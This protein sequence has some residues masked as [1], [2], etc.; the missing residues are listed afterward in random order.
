MV[1]FF[2]LALFLGGIGYIVFQ[3]YHFYLSLQATSTQMNRDKE[4][5]RDYLSEMED[6]VI[7]L[8]QDEIK[9]LSIRN[10]TQQ[11]REFKGTF[12]R[13]L[14][15]TVYTEPLFKFVLKEYSSSDRALLII[16]TLEGEILYELAENNSKVYW[17]QKLI[18]TLD[19]KGSIW[20]ESREIEIGHIDISETSLEQ[21]VFIKDQHVATIVN[22]FQ[23]STTSQRLFTH[24]EPLDEYDMRI[25][26]ALV[27]LNVVERTQFV[28][29]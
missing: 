3:M 7:P 8:A 17:D 27:L 29:A 11:V 21:N 10:E 26:L 4:E 6:E 18:G 28:T 19:D 5:L 20:N 16:Q 25:C 12:S 14:F 13:G 2:V 9:L 1:R 15:Y 23:A 24:L 22:P